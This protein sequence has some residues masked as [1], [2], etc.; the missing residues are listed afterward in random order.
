MV[1]IINNNNNDVYENNCCTTTTSWRQAQHNKKINAFC[2]LY[3]AFS[4]AIPGILY[5]W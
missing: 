1:L 5:R 3:L 2:G 4:V